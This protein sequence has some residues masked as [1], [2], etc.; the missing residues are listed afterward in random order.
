V[1]RAVGRVKVSRH[2]PIRGAVQTLQVRRE[3]RRWSAAAKAGLTKSILDA[4]WAQF[5]NGAINI[6]ARVGLGSSHATRRA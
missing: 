5:A 6:A 1:K 3:H 2:C 4:G